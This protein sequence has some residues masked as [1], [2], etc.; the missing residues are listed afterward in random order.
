M[1]AHTEILPDLKPETDMSEYGTKALKSVADSRSGYG[2]TGP[3]S[4]DTP[5]RV[6]GE[7]DGYGDPLLDT[8]LAS[9]EYADVLPDR[10]RFDGEVLSWGGAVQQYLNHRRGE[11]ASVES[12]DSPVSQGTLRHRALQKN[13]VVHRADREVRGRM[14]DPVLSLITLA[15]SFDPTE[16]RVVDYAVQ[17]SDALDSAMDTFRYQTRQKRGWDVEYVVLLAGTDDGVPHYH[18]VVWIDWGTMSAD[19]DT[20]RRVRAGLAPVVERFQSK[21]DSTRRESIEDDTG[22]P[23]GAVR[24]DTDP[25]EGLE[26]YPADG[27]DGPVH[28]FARYASNQV[29]H[30]GR[31][32]EDTDSFDGMTESERRVGAVADALPRDVSQWR[33]STGVSAIGSIAVD[34]SGS[35]GC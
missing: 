20:E 34:K 28:P 8:R 10:Y 25:N 17:L 12:D 5:E 9:D 27:R 32:T 21:L 30:L 18:M 31:A 15:G 19:T 14:E 2:T 35:T 6:P 7:F 23:D 3:E 26:R 4:D 11:R 33:S 29:P 13:A 24:V 1:L 22:I 16:V